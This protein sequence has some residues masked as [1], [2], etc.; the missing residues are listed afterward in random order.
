MGNCL[1]SFGFSSTSVERNNES[2]PTPCLKSYS[3]EDLKTATRKFHPD[4]LIEK[5]GDYLVFK[6]WIEEQTLS[7]STPETGMG[8]AVK[9]LELEGFPDHDEWL[10]KLNYVGQLHHPNLVKLIG[11]CLDGKH[12]ILVS[13][14]SGNGS[15]EHR[16]TRRVGT[17]PLS[18]ETRMKVAIGVAKGL[19]FL[20]GAESQVV[21]RYLDASNILLDDEFNAKLSAYLSTRIMDIQGYATQ[22]YPATEYVDTGCVSEKSD[23]Y[24]FGVLLRALSTGQPAV[25]QSMIDEQNRLDC[26]MCFQ[27]SVQIMDTN[28]EKDD[29]PRKAV[30]AVAALASQCTYLNPSLRPKMSEVLQKLQK[31]VSPPKCI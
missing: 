27:K 17:R 30:V 4:N 28:M 25:T 14:F 12:R 23:V 29:Y 26:V 31:V 3:F 11:Y 5:D 18:W 13:E 22:G 16:L 19:S 6:G 8:V 10:T 2:R 24:C 7:P 20:H 9:I 21:Y 15:L 1:A